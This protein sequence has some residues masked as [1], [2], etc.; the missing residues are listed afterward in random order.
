MQKWVV[1]QSNLSMFQDR[2]WLIMW[3]HLVTQ[4]GV[5]LVTGE[6]D[7]K[8]KAKAKENAATDALKKYIKDKPQLYLSFDYLFS[9]S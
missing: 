1:S 8:T 6:G 5:V 4:N 7:A 2:Y 3:L 9:D